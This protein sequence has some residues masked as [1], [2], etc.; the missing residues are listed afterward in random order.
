ME[1]FPIE[2]K[3][4]TLEQIFSGCTLIVPAVAG[5]SVGQLAVDLLV[6]T[7]NL[8]RVGYL[9]HPYILPCVGNDAYMYSGP[10]AAPASLGHLASTVEV[11]C[12]PEKRLVLI[13][14]RAPVAPG[15]HA[16]FA[17]SFASWVKLI[18]VR[19]VVMLA[20]LQ[21]KWRTEERVG[22]GMQLS[23][24]ATTEQPRCAELGWALLSD[25]EFNQEKIRG[26]RTPP[27]PVFC[28]LQDQEGVDTVCVIAFCSEGD[29]ISE[30]GAVAQMTADL[31]LLG[32]EGPDSGTPCAL[33]WRMPPSWG[34]LYGPAP[35]MA[36]Y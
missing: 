36:L 1:F 16:C 4:N 33:Q 28:A 9:E 17:A 15:R 19:K 7:L 12:L 11:F 30:G 18:G 24:L 26:A 31:L 5:A 20:G 6:S 35:D 25:E 22:L 34:N 27:W 21:A 29:N 8:K 32:Q 3:E 14:Q 13:Q 2:G 23:Y 10:G